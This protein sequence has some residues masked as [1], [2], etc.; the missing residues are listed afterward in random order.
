MT[1]NS[2]AT[3]I[4]G[5]SLLPPAI[6]AWKLF[7]DDQ[8]NSIHTV[9]AFS[10]DLNLLT[11]FLPPDQTLGKITTNDLNNF[12][13]WMQTGRGVP[14]SPKTLSRRITSI[15][16]FF[17]WLLTFGAVL[18]DPAAKVVQK[19]VIS[20]L[21]PVLSH[22]DLHI[23]LH[24]A[25][26]LRTIEKP[27]ARPYAL[28]KLLLDTGIKKGECLTLTTN[29]IDFDAP[30][31][32]IIFVRY[33]NPKYRYKERKISITGEWIEAFYEYNNQYDLSEK[34]FPWSPR[35]LEYLLEDIG[36][37]SGLENQLSFLMCRWTSALMD[38]LNGI[39]PNKI[40]Q[41]LGV[42]KIQFREVH[43]KLRKLAG[44]D[45]N[46]PSSD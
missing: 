4:D 24:T 9:K 39:E 14:C 36:K 18:V 8:G 15:K 3:H 23:A 2:S 1:S 6:H 27:D 37:Q 34:L 29:H 12:L 26:R 45:F 43:M 42:S 16:A 5:Q 28:F 31:G 13:E 33:E 17:K 19:S 46:I 20:P 7:L 40:R 32:P 11:S 30:K 35:R 22:T 21:P 25:N 38:L 44:P 41:K 10:A